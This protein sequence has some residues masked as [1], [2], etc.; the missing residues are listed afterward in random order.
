M[1]R[2][3]LRELGMVKALLI[4]T[5][6]TVLS[7]VLIYTTAA[8]LF[9]GMAP[10]GM[11]LSAA[12][13][14]ILAPSISYF[15]LRVLVR[16]DLAEQALIKINA[17]L[18]L[19]V[20]QRTAELVQANEELQTEVTQRKQTEGVLRRYSERLQHLHEIDQAILA[21]QSPED[22]ARAAL[23]HILELVPCQRASVVLS[24]SE[25]DEAV[26]LAVHLNGETEIETDAQMS[27]SA[28]G[29]TRELHENR[30]LSLE[31][32]S[33]VSDPPP[34]VQRLQAEGLR[35]FVIVPLVVQE[36]FLGALQLGATEPGTF[37]EDQ[38]EIACEVA[39]P[40]A[41]AIQQA[42]L[43]EETQARW[44]EAETLRQASA[45]LTETLSLDETL[46]HIL[47]QLDRV[48]PCDT[49]SVQ[50]L[51]E[52]YTEIVS[53]RGFSK[54][55]DVIGFRFPVPGANLN[56]VIVQECRPLVVPDTRASHPKF[57]EPP[58]DHIRSWMGVPLIVRDRLIGLLTVDSVQ[59]GHFGQ[60][61]LRLVT[62]FANQAAI[63]IQNAQLVEELEAEVVARMTEIVAEQERSEAIL[64]SVG[65]AIVMT[66]LRMQIQYVN[67][68]L[69]ALTGYTA[70]ESLG[71]PIQ[72]LMAEPVPEQVRQARLR[73]AARGETWQGEAVGRRKDGRTFDVALTI[74]PMHDAAGNLVGYVSS[75]RDI[76]QRKA[77]ER[78]R[79]QFM[80]NVS[81]QLRTPAANLRLY[82]QLLRIGLQSERA[83]DYLQILERESIRLSQLIHDILEMTEL[84]SG[85][86]VMT[87]QPVS[88][89]TVV[90][91]AVTR[92]KSQAETS[93]VTLE[94]RPMPADL[95]TVKGDLGRLTQALG[96]LVENA[97]IF[98]PDGGQVTI[99]VGTAEA[100]GYY[101]VTIT[102]RDTGPGIPPEERAQVFDRFFRGSLVAS[103]VIPGSGL[104]LSIA[105]EIVHAH[106]GRLTVESKVGQGSTFTLWLRSAS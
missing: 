81:H 91:D 73:A 52:G 17:E 5:L 103:G 34:A 28:F 32:L 15:L 3:L 40:L 22:V 27:L 89:S 101:W 59:P 39:R 44:R 84:D 87:W 70:E 51:R 97:V 66:D 68:A 29:F 12:V 63:A 1:V 42:R 79:S 30:I 31:D 83:G 53:G 45:A 69:T 100:E 77:L 49:A 80:V 10:I 37:K 96:E 43:L 19:W 65:E 76:S 2:E 75:H 20:K 57:F 35:S 9:G 21:A 41:I 82:A 61:H 74:A 25:A 86:A 23:G 46:A 16:L 93:G 18:E 7:S 67:D 13:P 56:T 54:L 94:A 62:P 55:E 95:P 71:Q 98:T 24:D 14:A 104:G 78:A 50:L 92:Y 6:I 85:Q 33:A 47:E 99:E 102:V 36:Q 90:G 4:I 11:V 64:R 48:V 38:I 8:I 105:Q 106:G 60:S 88:L 58:H 72:F 26:V